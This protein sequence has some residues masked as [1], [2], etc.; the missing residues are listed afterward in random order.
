MK[1]AV[2]IVMTVLHCGGSSRDSRSSSASGGG[3]VRCSAVV[4]IHRVSYIIHSQVAKAVVVMAVVLWCNIGSD[5]GSGSGSNSDSGYGSGSGSGGGG[6][7]SCS[8]SNRGISSDLGIDIVFWGERLW[9][10]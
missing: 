7:G 4:V 10:W 3:S 1:M 5:S 2:L 6:G 9:Y 8:N